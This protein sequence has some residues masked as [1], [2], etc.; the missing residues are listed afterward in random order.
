MLSSSSS[1]TGPVYMLPREMYWCP[2]HSQP[3]VEWFLHPCPCAFAVDGHSKPPCLIFVGP[4]IVHHI[5]MIRC[6]TSC[7]PGATVNDVNTSV[8]QLLHQRSSVT[9][10]VVHDDQ[11]SIK[12]SFFDIASNYN[13]S[14]LKVLYVVKTPQ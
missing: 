8:P 4:F 9:T 14:H 6:L 2:V 5:K 10:V 1:S 7:T 3:M 13:N 12:V 11:N